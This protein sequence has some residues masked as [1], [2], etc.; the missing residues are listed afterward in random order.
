MTQSRNKK[1]AFLACFSA[2]AMILSFLESQIPA[3]FAVPGMKLG[4]TNLL[5]VFALYE[6]GPREALMINIIRILLTG[7]LFGNP[8]SILYSLGGASLSFAAMF[9]GKR[10]GIFSIRGVSMLGGIFH[11][12]GQILVAAAAVKD[13]RITWYLPPLIVSGVITGFLI[14]IIALEMLRRLGKLLKT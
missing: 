6:W 5:I 2:A 7:F 14:G 13:F 10:C 1:R 4:L 9:L 12:V 8:Y 3:F 11:N